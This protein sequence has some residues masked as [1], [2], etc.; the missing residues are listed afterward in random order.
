MLTLA[1]L[2]QITGL[3]VT[4]SF[5]VPGYV[6]G[7]LAIVG[8]ALL[9]RQELRRRK[10]YAANPAP[11]VPPP[12]V[13][14]RP[15][16]QR[17]L[18]V[19]S[20]TIV[21]FAGL[22]AILWQLTAGL[23]ETADR[24][25]AALQS[26]D[27]DEARGFL[28]EDFRA[29]TSDEQLQRFVERSALANFESATWSNRVVQNSQGELRGTIRTRNGGSIP[30]TV[31]LI[32]EH[33]DW[34]ILSLRKPA[35]GILGEDERDQ[36]NAAEQMRLV[37]VATRDFAHAIQRKDFSQFRATTAALWQKESTVEQ[38]NKGFQAFTD[39]NADLT[40]LIE[41]EPKIRSAAFDDRG[42]FAI[43][44]TYPLGRDVFEYRYRYVF[45]GTE[46]KLVGISAYVK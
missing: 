7:P 21:A 23:A 15:G 24:F 29:A 28:S 44:G 4:F 1:V 27:M 45:E 43:A 20:A 41:I 30:M 39:R 33:G 19:I 40:P 8:G 13:P 3:L 31:V 12:V 14:R 5:G 37:R 26:R 25:F 35:A 46:W 16:W 6:I 38:L 9:L 2:L 18:I 17:V 22:F 11:P 34:K 36:P 42:F 32:R 10:H